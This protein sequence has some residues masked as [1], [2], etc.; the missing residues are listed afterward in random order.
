MCTEVTSVDEARAAFL[1]GRGT[2]CV[3]PNPYLFA[4]GRPR[5]FDE[6]RLVCCQLH[7][8]IRAMCR[9]F[10]RT[11]ATPGCFRVGAASSPSPPVVSLPFGSSSMYRG[12]ALCL[13]WGES[14]F[15]SGRKSSGLSHSACGFDSRGTG[16]RSLTG[17]GH[18][19]S[20]GAG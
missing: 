4:A 2:L 13:L 8:C 12:G 16:L 11:R 15:P 14:L 6:T 3:V 10:L 9:V 17:S 20:S 7:G 5:M 18:A 1:G 19:S